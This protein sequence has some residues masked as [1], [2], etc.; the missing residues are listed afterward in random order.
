MA[1]AQHSD[2]LALRDAL[3]A[4]AEARD[5]GQFHT[6]KNLAMALIG[7]AAEV[8][9]HFQWRTA[10]ASAALPAAD[11]AEVALELADVLLYLVRLA[12]VL[13]V[14]LADAAQRKLAINESRYPV[15][16]A[17]GRADKYTQL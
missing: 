8:V 12:D 2:L 1:A 9:E 14:D 7:E 4:F 10:E 11:R 17:H 16:K 13:E 3:R 5:W 15:D 6:P